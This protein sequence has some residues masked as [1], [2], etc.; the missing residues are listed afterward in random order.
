MHVFCCYSSTPKSSIP[1]SLQKRTEKVDQSRGVSLV[2]DVYTFDPIIS[3]HY[4]W[5]VKAILINSRNVLDSKPRLKSTDSVGA[6]DL[7]STLFLCQ[8][9]TWIYLTHT[10]AI[11]HRL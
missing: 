7:E 10:F 8:K 4:H 1:V 2:F 5:L 9:S 6:N 3:Q 11:F